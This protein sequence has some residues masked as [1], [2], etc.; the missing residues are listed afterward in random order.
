FDDRLTG[1]EARNQLNGLGGD[2]FLF[3]YGGIDYLKGG[4]GD[5]TIN[6]GAGSDYALFDGDR[7]S[8]TLT[9]SSGTEVTVSGPDGTDSLANVEYFRF[10]DMDVTIWELAIV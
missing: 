1:S 9:R 5:D 10:D 6:G 7:A 4:L 3:G 8:Y 2:D